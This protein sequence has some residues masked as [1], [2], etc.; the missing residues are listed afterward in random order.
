M[1]IHSNVNLC[2]S[3]MTISLTIWL[4]GGEKKLCEPQ[5]HMGLWILKCEFQGTLANHVCMCFRCKWEASGEVLQIEECI[6]SNDGRTRGRESMTKPREKVDWLGIDWLIDCS[7][8]NRN[9]ERGGFEV[10]FRGRIWLGLVGTV[11]RIAIVDGEE[12]W[13]IE[14]TIQTN[15]EIF[16]RT[17]WW[18]ED[19]LIKMRK[20]IGWKTVVMGVDS[21]GR[22]P[23]HQISK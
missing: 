11:T 5:R 2:P 3:L 14:T 10:R 12:W 7:T 18:N 17:D 1:R 20:L 23:Q 15:D 16:V 13:W 21:M 4:T 22:P 9:H 19:G 8:Q 6:F